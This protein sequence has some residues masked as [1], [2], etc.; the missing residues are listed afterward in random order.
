MIDYTEHASPLG[1]LLLAASEQRLIGVYFAEHKHFKGAQDWRRTGDHA[2][3][4][5]AGA[6]LDDYFAGRRTEF[7]LPLD[8]RGTEFQQ[9]V[10]RA[11]CAISFGQTRTYG[12]HAQAVG[13]PKAV[14]AVGAAI[15]RNPLSIVVPCHRVLGATQ[16]LTGYA[17]G[18]ERKRALLALEGVRPG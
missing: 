13:N 6:Q 12:Q 5:Q 10:W 14:R 8:L 17:G 16:G 4:R 3:L 18:L 7:D 2:L 1:P 11:L 9:G 15:G